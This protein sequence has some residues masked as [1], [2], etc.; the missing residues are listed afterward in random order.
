[1]Q[2]KLQLLKQLL[3]LLLQRKSE[4]IYQTALNSIGVDASPADLVDDVVG[5]AESVTN[6]LRNHVNMPIITGTS[7]LFSYFEKSGNFAR[8]DIPKEGYIVISPTGMGD[9]SIR[10]HVGIVGKNDVVMSNDSRSGKWM[11]NYTLQSWRARYSGQGKMPVY[12]Y[13]VI[14]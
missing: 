4:T 2:Q 8:V 12:F 3:N 13:K 6:I 11:A 10:G 14:K 1:M 9:G 7:S 5:C